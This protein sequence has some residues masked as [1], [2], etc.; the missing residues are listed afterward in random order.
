MI[1]REDGIY[2]YTKDWTNLKT[3][4]FKLNPGSDTG[5]LQ[6]IDNFDVGMLVTGSFYNNDDSSIY[7]CGYL[8]ADDKDKETFIWVFRNT[9]AID[10]S[11]SGQK[12]IIPELKGTQVESVFVRGN[13]IY[14]A[15]ERT[16]KAQKIYK[17]K[18]P[19]L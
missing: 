4:L 11:S 14:L 1:V 19:E 18:V 2:C 10:F 16:K 15:S 17:I 5:T 12:Y 13:Y 3:R 7:L 9:R 6:Y 8:N